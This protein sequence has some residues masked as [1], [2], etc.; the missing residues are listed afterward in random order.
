[1]IKIKVFSLNSAFVT[2]TREEDKELGPVENFIAQ[3]GYE[4][5]REIKVVYVNGGD[6][7]FYIIYEDNLPYAPRPIPEKKGLFG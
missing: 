3:I 4:N 7:H 2:K 1:M 5:I 6:T